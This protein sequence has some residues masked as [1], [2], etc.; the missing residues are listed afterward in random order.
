MF[1]P[2]ADKTPLPVDEQKSSIWS[3]HSLI[4]PLTK[5]LASGHKLVV[6]VR[7]H[8]DSLIRNFGTYEKVVDFL[9]KSNEYKCGNPN[10]YYP[11]T[12]LND[13]KIPR[14]IKTLGFIFEQLSMYEQ[15]PYE[16]KLL[17][18]YE[19]FILSPETTL[20][21][22]MHFLGETNWPIREFIE[23]IETH[24]SK[25]KNYYLSR[26]YG[27]CRS[28]GRDIHPYSQDLS[29]KQIEYIND[30]LEELDPNLFCKYLKNCPFNIN[31][32]K[33]EFL[34]CQ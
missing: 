2:T 22:I 5:E 15:W 14:H 21:K 23:E 6:L 1:T 13:K 34:L 26:P 28:N 32:E 30:P 3:G 18:Y 4:Q 25:S 20:R 19:E 11:L 24:S 27:Y 31:A 12:R 33:L 16:D 10:F 7:N 9:I 29:A 17:V 8:L